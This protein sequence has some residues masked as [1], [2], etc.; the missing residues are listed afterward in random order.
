MRGRP[1]CRPPETAG[2]VDATVGLDRTSN[3]SK[4]KTTTWINV[5]EELDAPQRKIL[6]SQ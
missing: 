2:R 4:S 5:T 3:F 6:A 1:K